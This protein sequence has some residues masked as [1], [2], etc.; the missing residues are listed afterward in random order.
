MSK[1]KQKKSK[2]NFRRERQ[3]FFGF[4][5]EKSGKLTTLK[6]VDEVWKQQKP[7]GTRIEKNQACHF[8]K[9]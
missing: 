6:F 2:K 9:F 8:N 7:N 5:T 1:K 4:L 3:F